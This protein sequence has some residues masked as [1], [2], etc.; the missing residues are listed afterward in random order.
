MIMRAGL[1]LC[2]CSWLLALPLYAADGD[3]S[4]RKA[5]NLS[6]RQQAL[7]QRIAKI[8]LALNHN[9]Y[10]PTYYQE[11][12]AAIAQFQDQYNE[13]RRYAPTT[14]VQHDLDRVESIW[15]DYKAV[16]DWSINKKGAEKLL[17]ICDPML[18]ASYQLFLSYQAYHR[19]MY[20]RHFRQQDVLTMIQLIKNAGL[21]R[22]LTQRIMLYYLASKQDIDG[23]VSKKKLAEAIEQYETSLKYI[24]QSDMNSDL[25]NQQLE[26]AFDHWNALSAKLGNFELDQK[27]VDRM[28]RTAD[29]LFNIADKVA[30][31]YQDLGHKLSVGNAINIAASQNVLTQ[32]IAKSYVAMAYSQ[33]APKYRKELLNSVELFEEQMLSMARSSES[34]EEFR[35]AV[36]VMQTMWKNYRKLVT[37]W[38]KMDDMAV[39]KVLERANI[40]MATCDKVGQAIQN[41]AQTIPEY[42]SFFEDGYGNRISDDSNIA[43][44]MRLAGLQRAYSQRLAIYFM[45]NALG[46]DSQLSRSRFDDIVQ[47]YRSNAEALQT[48]PLQNDAI[49]GYLKKASKQW[50]SIEKHLE[51]P[52]QAQIE[53]ILDQS[54]ALLNTLDELNLAYEQYMDELFKQH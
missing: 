24:T 37:S 7:T 26:A 52:D 4:I 49:R 32:R 5:L 19:T 36:N 54:T 10:E 46:I 21:Q 44:Q 29:E 2:L 48:S 6:T 50:E 9:L 41:H 53:Q 39:V 31:L 40:M 16:A 25:I 20:L 8:Y 1:L 27:E 11:R 45:M 3:V 38:D 13:L 23:D 28:I 15:Q 51:Q 18:D 30:L 33:N 17:Q 22:M 42:R 14:S 47:H 34:T 12:D 35:D 43:H